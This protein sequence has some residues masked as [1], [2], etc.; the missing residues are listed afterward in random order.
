MNHND[1]PMEHTGELNLGRRRFLQAGAATAVGTL[2]AGA[3]GTVPAHANSSIKKGASMSLWARGNPGRIQQV[4]RLNPRWYYTWGAS[5]LEGVNS[6]IVFVP[7]ITGRRTDAE[8]LTIQQK[9]DLVRNSSPDTVPRLLAFNEP[10]LEEQDDMT[11]EQVLSWWPQIQNLTKRVS[12]PVQAGQPTWSTWLGDWITEANNRGYRYDFIALHPYANP[13]WIDDPDEYLRAIDNVHE[14]FGRPVWITEFALADFQA[15]ES[16]PNRYSD[17]DAL[18]FMKAVLP[19]L[20]RRQHVL[21]YAWFGAGV[22]AAQNPV[23]Y[24]SRLFELD[25]TITELGQFYAQFGTGS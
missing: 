14:R 24:P 8:P 13:G 25:G 22:T 3:L 1:E 5:G 15:T 16:R 9:I 19:G 12:T 23:Y 7:M 18:A 17:A 20:E 11:V 2:A 10:N 6:D 21:R 4:N